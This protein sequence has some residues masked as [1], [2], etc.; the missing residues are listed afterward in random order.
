MDAVLFIFIPLYK[1]SLKLDK[2]KG[3]DSSNYDRFK[4]RMLLFICFISLYDSGIGNIIRN[5]KNDQGLH[6]ATQYNIIKLF[7][8]D[9]F[10]SLR[11]Q[12]EGDSNCK[13]NWMN[14]KKFKIRSKY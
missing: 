10:I 11:A 9:M 7:P 1:R 4:T 12:K 3:W 14:S 5:N 2:Y 13:L 6:I 8:N